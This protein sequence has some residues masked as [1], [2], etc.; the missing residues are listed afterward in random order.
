[1]LFVTIHPK[2]A[3][4]ITLQTWRSNATSLPNM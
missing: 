2:C 3:S 1:M 4:D